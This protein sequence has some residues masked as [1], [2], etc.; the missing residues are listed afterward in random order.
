[1]KNR[2]ERL[3]KEL[4]DPQAVRRMVQWGFA[5]LTIWIGIKFILFVHQA[6]GEGEITLTRPPGV[7][8]FLPI[9]ALISL[10]YWLFTGIFNTIHPASLVLLLV[11]IATA[12]LLKKGFCGW[13]CPFGLL[14]EYLAKIHTWIFGRPRRLPR[15]LDYPLRSLKYLLLGFFAYAIFWEMGVRELEAFINTPYNKVADVKMYLFFANASAFTIKVLAALVLLSVLVRYFWCRYLCP[16]GALLGI[17]GWLSPLK[18]RRNAESCIDCGKCTRVCPANIKVDK[19]VSVRSDECNACLRCVDACPVKDTLS[20]SVTPT[21]G[22]LPRRLYPLF[23]ILLFA[24]G[25]G[26]GRLFDRWHSSITPAEYRHH[27]RNIESPV[28]NHFRG[29]TPPPAV[30]Q[31]GPDSGPASQPADNK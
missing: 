10:K 4:A 7:E 20:F 22:V 2:V 18:V 27:I 5:L 9:S 24:V 8:A 13:V 26:A 14:S 15:W 29:R 28:Y 16:Y 6:G 31:T 17:L 1:M 12:L 21:R 3:R 25:I 23:L 19:A 11:I 30:R